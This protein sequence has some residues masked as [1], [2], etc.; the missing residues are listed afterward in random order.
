MGSVKKQT[1]EKIYEQELEIATAAIDL[2]YSLHPELEESYGKE[3]REK[4]RREVQVH[5]LNLAE[6]ILAS[7]QTLFRNH[8]AWA[9]ETLVSHNIPARNLAVSLNCIKQILAQRLPIENYVVAAKYMNRALQQLEEKT[10][11]QASYLRD[12]APLSKLA[13]S[14]MGLLLEG[15]QAGASRLILDK[16]AGGTSVRD[17]YLHIFQPV[18]YEIGRLWQHGK[19]TIAQEHYCTATTQ[20]IMSQLHTHF[21]STRKNGFK[22]LATCISDELHE[23]GVRMVADFFEVEGWETYYLGANTPVDSILDTLH[24]Q[25]PHLLLV[26]ATMACHVHHII[27]LITAIRADQ[28]LNDVKIMVGGNPFNAAPE[29]WEE[30]GADAYAKDAM[31]A[32]ETAIAMQTPYA[33]SA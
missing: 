6:S 23:I 12:D 22:L 29:L 27:A 5:L 7:S 32:L 15:N 24:A 11:S 13:A 21:F 26:S 14:Y 4:C 20:L 25:K 8:V 2:H 18:L 10:V 1:A 31:S 3:G 30:T 33:K 19:L 16:A 28:A 17:I 9:L